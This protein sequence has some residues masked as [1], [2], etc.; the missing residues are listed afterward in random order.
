MMVADKS[1]PPRPSVVMAPVASPRARK[2]VTMGMVL[3]SLGPRVSAA[4]DVTG[5]EVGWGGQISINT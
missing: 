5:G 1:L 2:P 3:G 4:W